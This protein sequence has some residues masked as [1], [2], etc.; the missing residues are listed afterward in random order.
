MP[1]PLDL[2][3]SLLI[4]SIASGYLL[5]A[6]RQSSPVAL[7]SGLGLMLLPFLVPTGLPLIALALALM[8]L[9]LLLNRR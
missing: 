5:Y 9:P 3:V 4:G 7:F 8:A 6:R 2:L 1:T